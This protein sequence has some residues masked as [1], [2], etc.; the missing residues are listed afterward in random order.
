MLPGFN[1]EIIIC[2]GEE[3]AGWF[4]WCSVEKVSAGPLGP[5]DCWSWLVPALTV[6]RQQVNPT[7]SKEDNPSSATLQLPCDPWKK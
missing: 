7:L 2:C 3:H 1:N 6:Q 5:A 4:A